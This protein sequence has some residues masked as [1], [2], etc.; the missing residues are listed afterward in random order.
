MS[1]FDTIH[2]AMGDILDALDVLKN[3]K[4]TEII[5]GIDTAKNDT[6]LKQYFKQ[7]LELIAESDATKALVIKSSIIGWLS[8]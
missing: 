1:N 3:E 8:Y 5:N 2:K 6:E 4:A 7:A